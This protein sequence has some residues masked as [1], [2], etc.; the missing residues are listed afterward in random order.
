[1]R[2]KEADLHFSSNQW[3]ELLFG[4]NAL[5]LEGKYVLSIMYKI[6]NLITLFYFY[7][8][9]YRLMSKQK[10]HISIVEQK[11]NQSKQKRF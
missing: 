10:L 6:S 8:Q 7:L 1:M 9:S 3:R 2:T 5:K 11:E 4:K